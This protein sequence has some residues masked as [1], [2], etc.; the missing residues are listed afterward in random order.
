[1]SYFIKIVPITYDYIQISR[2]IQE[3]HGHYQIKINKK[4]PANRYQIYLLY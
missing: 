3:R 4:V 2:L 1:M